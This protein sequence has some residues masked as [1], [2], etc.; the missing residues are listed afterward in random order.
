METVIGYVAAC[1]IGVSLGLIGGGGSILTVPILV[2]CF[3]IDPVVATAYSLFIVGITSLVGGLA[4]ASRNLV[5]LKTTILF[6]LPGFISVYLTRRYLIPCVPEKIMMLNS[7]VITKSDAIMILF[8]ILMLASGI[9]MVMKTDINEG[10]KHSGQFNYSMMLVT[11]FAVGILTGIVGMGGGF[12][13]IPA[14]VFFARLPMKK[15]VGTS[16]LIIALKSLIGFMG[17]VRV[18]ITIDYT[19]ISTLSVIAIA[20]MIFG[21]Y[22]SKFIAGRSLKVSFGCF[23][24]IMSTCLLLKQ[25]GAY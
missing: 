23:V 10:E 11:G 9:L 7:S 3:H 13:I 19:L 8:G 21:I 5:D 14:L 2:Y 6:S 22:T 15:A 24:I 12:L 25:A 18:G 20:G 16:L 4:N 1:L 17:D